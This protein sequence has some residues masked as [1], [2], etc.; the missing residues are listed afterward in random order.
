MLETDYVELFG[1]LFTAAAR[2]HWTLTAVRLVVDLGLLGIVLIS[3]ALCRQFTMRHARERVAREYWQTPA[4]YRYKS[5][6]HLGVGSRLRS[7]GSGA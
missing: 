4:V 2:W 7:A 5:T 3:I 1:T 6:H